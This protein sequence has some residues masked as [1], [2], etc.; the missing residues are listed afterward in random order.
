MDSSTKQ[1]ATGSMR[2]T[3]S[4]VAWEDRPESA[5]ATR[6]ISLRQQPNIFAGA[7]D[8]VPKDAPLAQLSPGKL[9]NP[10]H[11]KSHSGRSTGWH[12]FGEHHKTRDPATGADG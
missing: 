5:A 12:T 1:T 6:A 7:H 8:F 2:G 10:R 9:L 4:N 11:F 3:G